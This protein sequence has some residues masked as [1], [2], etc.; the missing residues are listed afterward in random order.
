[1]SETSTAQIITTTT[2]AGAKA[3]N[4]MVSALLPLVVDI[5]VPL[6]VYYAA[7]SVFGVSLVGSLIVSSVVPAVRTVYGLARKRE[8]NGM[9]ALML[10]VN[11]VGLLTA[12]LTG[13]PRLMIAKDGLLSSAI[14]AGI[15]V[16]ALRGEPLMA[17]GL[18]PFLT[19]GDARLEAAWERLA[20]GSAAGSAAFAKAARRHSLIWG[21]AL[22]LECAARVVGAYT[23]PLSTM[24]WLP[25]VFLIGAIVLASM[26]SDSATEQLK[27]LAADEA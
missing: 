3:A 21:G 17:A 4:P 19:R 27:K 10:V 8:F 26:V 11:L 2:E 14:G 5:A 23:L 6:G 16:S 22:L 9:A 15:L 18:R 12:F 20:A 13:D 1:M 24:A 7:H 25:T